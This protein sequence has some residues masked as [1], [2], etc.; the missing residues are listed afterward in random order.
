MPTL[1]QKVIAAAIEG[2]ELQKVELDA[3]IATLRALLPSG[4]P[5]Q[6][7]TVAPAR[8]RFTD[9]TRKRMAAAQQK[10]W[11]AYNEAKA[12]A[13]PAKKKR[14]LSAAGRRNI[15]A[16][17]KRRWAAQKAGKAGKRTMAAHA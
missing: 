7:P 12:E 13:P 3:Q 2:F 5:L 1:N 16:A 15:I 9:A 11:D 14:T 4:Q 10:R 8:R 6:A 17:L